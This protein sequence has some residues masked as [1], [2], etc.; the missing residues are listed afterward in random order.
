[1]Y[2]YTHLPNFKRMTKAFIFFVCGYHI[3]I[4]CLFSI[5]LNPDASFRFLVFLGRGT[6]LGFELGPQSSY[7]WPPK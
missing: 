2:K 3:E 6:I 7:I 4:H 5:K 1:M